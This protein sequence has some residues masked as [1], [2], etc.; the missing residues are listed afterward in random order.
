MFVQ[1]LPVRF[2]AG[3]LNDYS[4][5]IITGIIVGP[6]F[7]RSKFQRQLEK[8][9][10]QL[11]ARRGCLKGEIGSENVEPVRDS[12]MILNTGRVAEQMPNGDAVPRFRRF[13]KIFCDCVLKMNPALLNQHHDCRSSELLCVRTNFVNR[14]CRCGRF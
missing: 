7:A 3:L 11:I 12:N 2:A 6:G 1:E 10:E 8:H 5:Q 9:L 4:E 13:W 14:F